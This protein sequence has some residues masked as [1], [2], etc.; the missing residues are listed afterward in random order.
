MQTSLAL[1]AGYPYDRGP[2][3]WP[4]ITVNLYTTHRNC[5]SWYAV[6][7]NCCSCYSLLVEGSEPQQQLVDIRVISCNCKRAAHWSGAGYRLLTAKNTRS[8][9]R[10]AGFPP[11]RFT[12]LRTGQLINFI[13]SYSRAGPRLYLNKLVVCVRLYSR[14]LTTW[15]GISPVSCHF[16]TYTISGELSE[17]LQE[18]W[19]APRSRN[20]TRPWSLLIIHT[21]FM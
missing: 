21:N 11:I 19:A 17:S 4:I 2:F 15:R 5:Y 6:H 13:M 16:V 8:C 7:H 14:Y 3:Y 12:S 10:P 9:A 20:V 18:R 1:P